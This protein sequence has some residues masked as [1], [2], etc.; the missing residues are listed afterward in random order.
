M[1]VSG[2]SLVSVALALILIEVNL[3][4]AD[5][6]RCYLYVFIRLDVFECFLQRK[7]GRRSDSHFFIRTR[8]TH[9]G[10]LLGLCNVDNKVTSPAVLANYLAGID[11][12]A[13]VDK[14]FAAVLQVVQTV[15][16]SFSHLHANQ[17]TVDPS[18]DLTAIRLVFFKSM[19]NNS[20]SCGH[21]Q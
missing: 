2:H 15:G 5:G 11:W 1:L 9:V 13:R 17:R 12:V 7:T 19:C 3:A 4:Q 10:Q 8:S 21:V 18:R 14:E 16:N 20:L 6:F